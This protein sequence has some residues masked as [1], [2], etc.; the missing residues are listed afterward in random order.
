[1][2]LFLT[3]GLYL[4]S[5]VSVIYAVSCFRRSLFLSLLFTFTYF[6]I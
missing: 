4:F 2:Y 5:F 1:M 3:L 6:G